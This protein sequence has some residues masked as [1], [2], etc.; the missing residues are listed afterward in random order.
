MECEPPN[1]VRKLFLKATY[2]HEKKHP[3][4]I[5]EGHDRPAFLGA[6]NR[7]RDWDQVKKATHSAQ[8]ISCCLGKH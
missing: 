4:R 7:L 6:S 1:S 2:K 3:I 8:T 5:H